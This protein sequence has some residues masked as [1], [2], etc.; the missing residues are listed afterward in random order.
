M[1]RCPYNECDGEGIL[2]YDDGTDGARD[3]LCR[4]NSKHPENLDYEPE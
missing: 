4:C 3:E 1:K 2:R